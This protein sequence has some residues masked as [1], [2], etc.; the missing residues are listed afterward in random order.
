MPPL[1]DG[2]FALVAADFSEA[3]DFFKGGGAS[4]DVLPTALLQRA[5]ALLDCDDREYRQSASIARPQ[6]PFSTDERSVLIS[7]PF[8]RGR[9]VRRV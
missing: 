1:S 6:G 3:H 5:H 2:L 8:Y 9:L 7:I 4:F